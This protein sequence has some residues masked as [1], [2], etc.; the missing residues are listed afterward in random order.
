VS[1]EAPE[2]LTT[3][4]VNPTQAPPMGVVE[5]PHAPAP[6]LLPEGSPRHGAIFWFVLAGIGIAV[7]FGVVFVA[8]LL[9]SGCYSSQPS[10]SSQSTVSRSTPA[11]SISA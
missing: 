7:I 5:V 2:P 1:P 11:A 6:Q 3:P 4:Y 8:T 10:H 9:L